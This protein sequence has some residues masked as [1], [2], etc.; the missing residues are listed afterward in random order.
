MI[1][2]NIHQSQLWPSGIHE[3]LGALLDSVDGADYA[4]PQQ[5]REVFAE[6]NE[7]LDAAR[8]RL[9]EV[10]GAEVRALNDAIAAAGLP[11]VG[12][13]NAT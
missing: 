1:D 12:A 8:A 9:E 13:G 5:A 3:K 6:L 7:Q 11:V 10:E 2:V 4:P